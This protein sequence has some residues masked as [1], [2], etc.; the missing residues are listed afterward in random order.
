MTITDYISL[1]KDIN[2]FRTEKHQMSI[3]LKLFF[4]I[5]IFAVLLAFTGWMG[6]RAADNLT[7]SFDEIT[8]PVWD[9]SIA[10]AKG[11]EA[12]KS[13]AL[14]VENA[15]R[16]NRIISKDKL[17]ELDQSTKS[18]Y[19]NLISSK[20]IDADVLKL[21]QAKMGSYTL[22]RNTLIE[23][24]NLYLSIDPKID[25]N[26]D[27]FKHILNQVELITSQNI[28]TRDINSEEE[29]DEDGSNRQYNDEISEETEAENNKKI[30]D[31][32]TIIALS[33][34]EYNLLSRLYLYGNFL[35]DPSDKQVIEELKI[36]W[37]DL[38]YNIET[39]IENL[40]A[41]KAIRG[42]IRSGLT[43][44]Q[45]L[46]ELLKEHKN[47]F[48][49]G[50]IKYHQ[51]QTALKNY[52]Q[53]TQQLEQQNALFN[54][55]VT[56]KIS[57][58]KKLAHQVTE[59]AYRSILISIAIGLFI[60]IPI[61]FIGL[62]TIIKPILNVANQLWDIAQGDGD[63]TVKLAETGDYEI[64]QLGS[65]FNAFSAKLEHTI[66]D[67][68][69]STRTLS[70]TTIQITSVGNATENAV[71]EQH[72]QIDILASTMTELGSKISA[73]AKQTQQAHEDT[74]TVDKEAIKGQEIVTQTIK[75]IEKVEYEVNQVAQTISQ[76]NE[77]TVNISHI[78]DVIRTISD[79]TNL[80]ALNAAIEAARAGDS[81]RGFAVVADEVRG[82]ASRTNASIIEIE[83]QID[84]L[85]KA[86]KGA[87]EA[88]KN[89]SQH[90]K[91]TLKPANEAGT[92]L[93]NITRLVTGI[94]ESISDIA[95]SAQEQSE[96]A[97][98]IQQSTEQI[99]ESATASSFSAKALSESTY[100]L[101]GLAT[102][103][104]NLAAEYKTIETKDIT[105]SA[106]T[107]EEIDDA[108]F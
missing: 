31:E 34:A 64:A 14:L 42:D 79:Q 93:Q 37:E 97:N 28:L 92:A 82:L 4:I 69:K 17:V 36:A 89:A 53:Q 72:T 85:Q 60:C 43:H 52:S 6:Y 84:Q 107:K 96:S 73:V 50:I 21:L 49:S 10:V 77:D 101:V 13:Q 55:L 48:N 86:S 19:A 7:H 23:K 74:L 61:Y 78:L 35:E 56:E 46:T 8:G 39:I 91:D 80:L 58:E 103:L 88:M 106:A 95:S 27:E 83:G 98:A 65:G 11:S 70:G 67:L 62:Q 20:R 2:Y 105:V 57:T 26:I 32:D 76:L 66:N 40:Y 5:S 25:Q 54:Q 99:R 104:S 63:L 75:S 87:L 90:T 3:K 59:N 51:L 33:A 100:D 30:A 71:S 29:S 24:N 45:A 15:L 47:I 18:A 12:V 16:Q 44:K 1:T 22:S 94:T 81:G 41:D 9:I 102:D 38:E 108:F 68:K